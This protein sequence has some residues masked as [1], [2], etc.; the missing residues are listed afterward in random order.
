MGP[1]AIARSSD[2]EGKALPSPRKVSRVCSCANRTHSQSERAARPVSSAGRVL[3]RPSGLARLQSQPANQSGASERNGRPYD[4]PLDRLM[5]AAFKP[6]D[7]PGTAPDSL[8]AVALESRTAPEATRLQDFACTSVRKE[9]WSSRRCLVLPAASQQKG[10]HDHEPQCLDPWEP[11]PVRQPPQSEEGEEREAPAFP[12]F[13]ASVASH[14]L[15]RSSSAVATSPSSDPSTSL[16]VAYLP[17]CRDS[18]V[19]CLVGY[20]GNCGHQ[21]SGGRRRITKPI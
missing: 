14:C 20:A 15:I 8:G 2:I 6:L 7:S 4:L 3:I 13:K 10:I 9:F 17:T 12:R 1:F 21:A 18:C 5:R 19:S 11:R 16:A